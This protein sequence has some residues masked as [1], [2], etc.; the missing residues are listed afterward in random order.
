MIRDMCVVVQELRTALMRRATKLLLDCV[1]NP[2]A[3]LMVL[4]GAIRA[5]ELP[6]ILANS[7]EQLM[8]ATQL[9][10][11]LK[12]I[13]R[14]HKE[15]Y[16]AYWQVVLGRAQVGAP[17]AFYLLATL[18]VGKPDVF[19]FP[20]RLEDKQRVKQMLGKDT[21]V[22]RRTF[23]SKLLSV[24]SMTFQAQNRDIRLLWEGIH[25]LAKW[26][27]PAYTQTTQQLRRCLGAVHTNSVYLSLVAL[28][29]HRTWSAMWGY[30][31]SLDALKGYHASPLLCQERVYET[32][33][34]PVSTL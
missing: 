4:M 32:P 21:D 11:L 18:G 33:T 20:Q 28:C 30:T 34:R 14:T 17:G 15:A 26:S 7:G 9:I 1:T 2:D 19:Q 22:N 23:L 27:L 24:D 25:C 6:N 3:A 8:T 16:L 12:R 5:P 13:P 29:R 31:S 10:A